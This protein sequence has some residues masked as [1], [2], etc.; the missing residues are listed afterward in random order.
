MTEIQKV[1]QLRELV[2]ETRLKEKLSAELQHN[3]WLS[4][5]DQKYR[6][7]GELLDLA[8]VVLD[9]LAVEE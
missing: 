9:R 4:H 1:R 8:V 3:Y 5:G 2:K 6:Q 7:M